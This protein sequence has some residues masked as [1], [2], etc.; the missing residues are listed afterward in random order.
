MAVKFKEAVERLLRKNVCFRCRAVFK[1]R[2]C[3]KCG[4]KKF[5]KKAAATRG[6]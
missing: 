1:G 5:R 3:P 2:Q 6:M 4:S